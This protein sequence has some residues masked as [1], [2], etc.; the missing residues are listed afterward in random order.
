VNILVTSSRMPFALDVIR[1]FGRLGHRVFAA[2]TFA[3]AP[4]GHSRWV[5]RRARV[6]A[7]EFL[8]TQFLDD[9]ERLVRTFAIDLVVPCFEEVFYLARHAGDR[10]NG[11]LFAAGLEPLARLHHKASLNVLAR[12]LGIAA[13]PTTLV[14]TP[15]ELY[16]A[17]AA[18]GR[19]FA[20]PAWSRGGIE[21]CTNAGPLAGALPL[22]QCQPTPAR[23]WIVQEYVDGTDVCGFGVAHHG[24]LVAH[25]TYVHPRQ[26]D[27]SGGIVFESQRD[28]EA[29][30]CAERLVEAT[31]YHGQISLDFRRGERGLMLLECNPRPTA[32]V[33]LMPDAMFV[34]AVLS[35]ARDLRVVPAGVRRMYASA[36][37]R[38]LF[39]HW[40]ELRANLAYLFSDARDVYG[41]H[42]D[43]MPALYQL[44]SYA[45]VMSYRLR[46]RRARAAL[47]AAYFEGIRW[48]GQPI[49]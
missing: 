39:L 11:E 25:C 21:L 19:Y 3:S 49:P 24:R 45:R 30:A 35:P 29:L 47:K 32:G 23:P 26:L 27:G 44:L 36:L 10:F 41:E 34:D 18:L 12:Q 38:D 37:V 1:K 6:A 14:T 33:H 15:D 2:D 22:P 28:P 4:G 5:A 7:P 16:A 13:P 8:P 43:R 20:R 9:V 31:G 40:G 42:G 17:A 46:H 48:D